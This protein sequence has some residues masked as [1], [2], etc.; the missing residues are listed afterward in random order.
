[1]TTFR[2][3]PRQTSRTT[4]VVALSLGRALT[5]VV[6]LA[7]LMVLSRMLDKTGYATYRQTILAFLFVQPFM[8]LGLGSSVYY[9]LPTAQ[10]NGRR[11][12]SS[13]LLIFV[14]V[15]VA[16]GLFLI[17]WGN[18]LLSFRFGNPEIARTLLYLLP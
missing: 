17:L 14:F 3:Q 6:S 12:V 9:F 1:M 15:G 18:R 4:K 5:S 2:Q 10:G 16:F 11:I 7:T 8:T 13:C